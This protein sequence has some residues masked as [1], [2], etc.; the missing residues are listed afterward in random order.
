MKRSAFFSVRLLGSGFAPVIVF[1]LCLACYLT[2]LTQ[3]HTFDALSYVLDVD[4]KPWPELF[5][6]HHLA[7]GP[8]GVLVRNVA[9]LF[10][11]SGSVMLPLQITNALAGALGVALFFALVQD[12]TRRFDLALCAALLLGASYAYWYYA[13]EVEVYT[14]ATLFLIICLWLI[15]RQSGRPRHWGWIALGAT[16]G[17]AV[18]F[19]QTNVLLSAP[20]AWLILSS[21]V[22]GKMSSGSQMSGEQTPVIQAANSQAQNRIANRQDYVAAKRRR[23][24]WQAAQSQASALAPKIQ[25]AL[26]YG[27]P[28][29][30][31]VVGSYFAVG[32]GVSGF[33]SWSAFITWMG[34]Y[35]LTGW[36]G[37]PITT[38]KWADLSV[39]LA[40]T[41]AQPG[42]ALLGL[43][44]V[45]LL[46]CYARKLALAY[47]SFVLV[48]IV[49]LITYGAFF[50]WWEPDNIEFWIASLP[51]AVFL[52]VLAL[53]SGGPRWH[54]GVWVA[55]TLGLAIFGVNYDSIVRRG[56]AAYDL[57][58]HIARGLAQQ[59]ESRDLILVPDGLQEL[60]LP[61]YEGRSNT[62]SLN[63]ILFETGGNWPAACLRIQERV[64]TALANGTAILIGD[65][66]LSPSETFLQRFGLAQDQITQCFTSYMPNWQPI[67]LGGGLPV[68]YRLPSAEELALGSGWRFGRAHWGWRAWNVVDEHIDGAWTFVPGV[69]PQIASPFLNMDTAQ[70]QAI[71]IRMAASTV[72]HD[73]QLFFVDGDGQVDETR[74]IRWTLKSEAVMET[75]RLELAGQP[76]WSGVVA[77]LR[78]DPVSVGDGG[79]VRLESIQ[80]IREDW[81][82]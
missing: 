64:E 75:Y 38:D 36:W 33:R 52:L 50:L 78:L 53:G 71:E 22:G 42:G 57:Q 69:D 40:E 39:G 27:M 25:A 60:Y 31:V 81:R 59:S 49:W 2:T 26:L 74:S 1:L 37:G 79:W 46:V 68:Y 43:L 47:P 10:G 70:F 80:L 19:H 76:G 3:V 63:Q 55:L 5:H 28:L 11:W 34:G 12:V 9:E 61:Y 29:T 72:A 66:A 58:R 48:S 23:E 41:L 7:Y 20:I 17:I 51:P 56:M 14:I 77:G 15:V 4:R 65:E 35:A 21:I 32:F 8:V 54:P 44:L 16:Q 82:E 18:L 6:P 45:G 62:L 30:L 13:V 73:A 67:E 24:P